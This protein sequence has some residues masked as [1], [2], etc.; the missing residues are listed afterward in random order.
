V[1]PTVILSEAW[2]LYKR[3]WRHLLPIALVIYLLLSLLVLLLGTLLGWVG[4]IAG[5]F[6]SIVGTF[7]IQGALVLAV[8]DV[9]DG[10]A[11]LTISETMS[12]LRPRINTLTVTGLLASIAIVIGLALL[13][14]PGLILLTIW[15][16]IVP[17][18]MLEGA[19][20][21]ESFGRSRELVRGHGWDV[22][23][24]LVLTIL[25]WIGAS[26]VLSILLI[27][28]P[29]GF[30]GYLG[31]VLSNTLFTPFVAAAWTLGYYRLKDIKAAEAPSPAVA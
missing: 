30:G 20:I 18:I 3:H 10:R 14:V 8:Q 2:E 5:F 26:I 4:I 31:S 6:V 9:R 29:D 24:L 11:D 22:F 25:I 7:W 23:G 27:P 16:F 19:G 1:S 12:R 17:V 15:L 28:L 21:T 13:V